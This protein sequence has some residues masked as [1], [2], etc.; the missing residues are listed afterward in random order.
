MSTFSIPDS[1]GQIIQANRSETRGSFVEAFSLDINKK[2]GKINTSKK[3]IQVLDDDDDLGGGYPV[4]FAIFDGYYYCLS[5]DDLVR[6][7]TS[8]D[9]T[10]SSNWSSVS[11]ITS[12]VT[13]DSD[14][15]VFDD[16]LL[17]TSG[18]NIYSLT[19]GDVFASNWDSGKITNSAGN[20]TIMHVYRGSGDYVFIAEDNFV[21]Y[22][23]STAGELI[24]QLQADQLVSS[25]NSGVNRVWVGVESTSDSNA[26]VYEIVPNA[27]TQIKNSSGT[28]VD[29]TA[30]A[31]N[32]Y[33][34]EGTKVM[35]IEMID[36]VPYILTEKGNLQAFNGAGFST[37][38][39]FPF[40]NT[41][42]VISKDAVHHKGMKL[43]EESLF[44]NIST[45]RRSS[46]ASDNVPGCPSGIWE[47]NR[48]TGQLHHRFA[49]ADTDNDNGTL[50][51]QSVRG[52]LMVI[53]NEYATLLAGAENDGSDVSG[54]FADTGSQFGWFKTIEIE[55]DSVM[56]AYERA[57]AMAKTMSSGESVSIKYRLV[58]K[59]PVMASGSLL[60]STTFNTTDDLS[61]ITADSDG[62]YH[63]Q[64]MD[65]HT[66][67]MAQV[68]NVESSS[69]T[70]S[71][72]VDGSIGTAGA[73]VRAMF[74]N[75][76]KVN[77]TYTSADAEFKSWGGFG[78]NPWVQFFVVLDGAIEMRRFVV[79]SNVQHE[80]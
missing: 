9:P 41:T 34:V 77:D 32:A 6:C 64:L 14:L 53:D 70:Y 71:V 45:E 67:K 65:I 74:E 69:G 26:Y 49:F 21:H 43:H 30:A 18:G 79:S 25:I 23:N 40:A 13:S 42:E 61:G 7:L 1:A 36:N 48:V 51:T 3:M 59:D 33:K 62:V 16:L 20:F 29:V 17:I 24:V 78:S 10:D 47:Y 60:D 2:F 19:T 80:T 35:S 46:L 75:W 68:T 38:T 58:K 11:E 4:A 63:W 39:S 27:I 57:Y 50:E 15:A 5:S 73:S 52:P 8:D 56:A 66:G 72:T 28:V 54:V 44:I 12:A 55:T 76:S 31:E 22:Y 37:V